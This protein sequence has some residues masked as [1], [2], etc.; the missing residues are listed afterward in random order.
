MM[1][2]EVRDLT[3]NDLLTS[4][5]VTETSPE[6]L[7]GVIRAVVT[8]MPQTACFIAVERD[9]AGGELTATPDPLPEPEATA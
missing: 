8:D 1:L 4:Y 2:L 9:E 5:D 6:D 3:T 7:P